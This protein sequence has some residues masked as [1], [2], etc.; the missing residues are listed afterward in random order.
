MKVLLYTI[1]DFKPY[2]IECIDLLLRSIITDI[3]Y[4]FAIIS[5]QSTHISTNHNIIVDNNINHSY[6]YLKYSK[7]IPKN[8]DYY[9]Y[10]DSDILYF[11]KISKLLP[12]YKQFT[13]VKE[14][15]KIEKNPWFYYPFNIDPIE[16]ELIQNSEAINAGSFAYNNNQLSII[17]TI[18]DMCIKHHND[19]PLHN[20]KLEQSSF[21]Y[22]VNKNNNFD[23]SN[24]Y[25]IT[26]ATMLFA[27]N[28]K[29]DT[30]KVLYHFCGFTGEMITKYVNMKKFYELYTNR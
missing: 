8:Y 30:N 16:D 23:L 21:N 22:I 4:D 10:L 1:S 27:S 7:Q 2:S 19:D 26:D 17:H 28:K 29:P 11:D 6:I 3:Y 13:I 24:C 5:N 9:I 12:L 14:N 25:D 15:M 20:A 18:Y